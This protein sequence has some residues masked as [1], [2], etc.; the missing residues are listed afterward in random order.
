MTHQR[1]EPITRAT[2]LGPSLSRAKR[3]EAPTVMLAA[4]VT[5]VYTLGV[6]PRVLRGRMLVG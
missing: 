5:D 4:Q 1:E 2:P 3:L 6:W